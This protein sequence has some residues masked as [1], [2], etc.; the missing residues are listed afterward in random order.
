MADGQNTSVDD[1]IRM[2]I[3]KTGYEEYLRTSQQDFDSRW[4]NVQ[5]L[6]RTAFCHSW[7][8]RRWIE[9]PRS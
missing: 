6:V 5:E 9:G 4:E 7:V 8:R 1:L 3:E 2:I